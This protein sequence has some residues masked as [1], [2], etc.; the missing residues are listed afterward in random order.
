M[1]NFSISLFYTVALNATSQKNKYLTGTGTKTYMR[2]VETPYLNPIK[3]N[4]M[5]Y[6]SN[7]NYCHRK[8]MR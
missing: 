3:G 4:L 5:A 7:S 2:A 8:L 6:I 1:F